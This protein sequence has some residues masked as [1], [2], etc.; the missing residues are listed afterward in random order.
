MDTR[1]PEHIFFSSEEERYYDQLG[2]ILD[3]NILDQLPVT[4]TIG[5]H[6]FPVSLELLEILERAVFAFGAGLSVYFELLSPEMKLSQF[7]GMFSETFPGETV[8]DRVT[9]L[10]GKRHG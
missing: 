8:H 5:S 7:E 4:V 2:D 10:K 9:R 3:K 1:F 6:T